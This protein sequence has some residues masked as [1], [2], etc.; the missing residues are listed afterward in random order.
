MSTKHAFRRL[1]AVIATFALTLGTALTLGAAPASA[2]QVT[3]IQVSVNTPNVRPT[4]LVFVRGRVLNGAGRPAAGAKIQVQA[5]SPGGSFRNIG[6]RTANKHGRFVIAYRGGTLIYR[7]IVNRDSRYRFSQSNQVRVPR[8]TAARTFSARQRQVGFVVGPKAG[9]TRATTRFGQRV[10]LGNYR[11]GILAKVGRSTSVVYGVMLKPYRDRGG[12][13]GRL[14]A[15]VADMT[16]QLM[17]GACMQRFQNGTMYI[18]GSAMRR[19]SVAFGRGHNTTVMAVAM[20][21]VGYKEPYYRGGK[22]S[23]WMGSSAAWCGFLQSWVGYASGNGD[24]FPRRKSFPEQVRVVRNRGGLFYRPRV[25]SYAFFGSKPS[26][27]GL[28]I[29]IR[30]GGRKI[31]TIEGNVDARGSNGHPRG[32]FQFVRSTSNVKFYAPPR[33]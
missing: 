22:H 16:C 6:R 7:A 10:T 31:V 11:N 13:G 19:V 33:F 12:V 25:G 15:P 26:H 18:N 24:A 2:A 5:K 28:I 32:V 17:E 30:D 8:T 9:A 23:K 4:E 14:G 21:Q 1:T 3:R 20:S 29:G 27:V